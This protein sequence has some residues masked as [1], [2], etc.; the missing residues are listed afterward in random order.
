[1]KKLILLVL[2][3]STV[4]CTYYFVR[5]SSEYELTK[6]DLEFLKSKKIGLIGFYPFVYTN[7]KIGYSVKANSENIPIDNENHLKIIRFVNN[8]PEKKLILSEQKNNFVIY[9]GTKD[10]LRKTTAYFD[11]DR[12]TIQ[13]LKYGTDLKQIESQ[14]VNNSIKEDKLKLFLSEYLS[15]TKHLGLEFVEHLVEFNS[16]NNSSIL[17]MKEFD[18]DYWILASHGP[19]FQGRFIEPLN[20]ESI[21]PKSALSIF[22]YALTLGTFPLLSE[23]YTESSFIVFDKNLNLIKAYQYKSKIDTMSAWWI[24]WNGEEMIVKLNI[25]TPTNIYEADIKQ[26][27]KELVPILQK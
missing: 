8:N 18:V 27:S 5:D 15:N 16:K 20:E 7:E 21:S 3:F 10:G 1:M 23:Y 25:N 9:Q 22:P 19:A 2:L 14:K 11:R 24:F 12:Q 4:N 13:F 26:F 6:K 17:K